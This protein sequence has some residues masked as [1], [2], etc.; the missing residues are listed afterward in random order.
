MKFIY[1]TNNIVY[2]TTVMLYLSLFLYL[3][4]MYMQ[5]LLG[6]VQV[7]L[8][9]VLLYNYDKFSKNIQNHLI[10]YGVLTGAFLLWFFADIPRSDLGFWIL[11]LVPMSISTYFSY[12]VYQLKQHVL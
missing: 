9:F 10:A 5:I 6:I 11:I 7:L 3:L 12:I 2:S 1:Y 8:F 4:G